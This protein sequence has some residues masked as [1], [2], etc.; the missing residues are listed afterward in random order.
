MTQWTRVIVNSGRWWR[1]GKAGMMHIMGSQR[2]GHDSYWTTSPGRP[3]TM[4]LL[5]IARIWFLSSK[6][7]IPYTVLSRLLDRHHGAQGLYLVASEQAGLVQRVCCCCCCS[8]ESIFFFFIFFSLW[9]HME[10]SEQR[11]FKL[12]LSKRLKIAEVLHRLFLVCFTYFLCDQNEGG[13]FREPFSARHL[14]GD[15]ALAASEHRLHK[16]SSRTE[17]VL[18]LRGHKKGRW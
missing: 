13:T 18:E 9:Y 3:G 8:Q 6:T 4:E 7:L 1:T 11:Q 15:K 12:P 5:D 10:V 2:V 17:L 16:D 14:S